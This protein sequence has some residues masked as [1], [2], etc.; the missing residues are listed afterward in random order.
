MIVIIADLLCDIRLFERDDLKKLTETY[1]VPSFNHEYIQKRHN[2]VQYFFFEEL[3]R[4]DEL[5]WGSIDYQK[6]YF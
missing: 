5:K 1:K 3:L 6:L 2:I 4:I